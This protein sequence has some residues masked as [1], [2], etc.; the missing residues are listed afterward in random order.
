[1]CRNNFKK[2]KMGSSSFSV[3]TD[4]ITVTG[5]QKRLEMQSTRKNF[6]KRLQILS[7]KLLWNSTQASVTDDEIELDPII[8]RRH[9]LK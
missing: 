7:Q 5:L 2:G 9:R 6:L 1:M 3:N 8:R 4:I